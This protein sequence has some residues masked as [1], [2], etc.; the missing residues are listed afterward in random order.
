MSQKSIKVANSEKDS[1]KIS[2][3]NIRNTWAVDEGEESQAC[4]STSFCV[5]TNATPYVMFAIS[6]CRFLSVIS[7]E[8]YI[9]VY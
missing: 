8:I 2:I 7:F 9:K 6:I 4:K 3:C 1:V 5:T